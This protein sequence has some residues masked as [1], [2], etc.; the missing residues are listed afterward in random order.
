[1]GRPMTPIP[2]KPSCMVVYPFRSFHFDND[3]SAFDNVSLLVVD[4]PYL[5]RVGGGDGMFHFH[6]AENDEYLA[7]LHCVP[8]AHLDFGDGS[9]HGRGE[10][11]LQA[12]DA[13]PTRS[14]VHVGRLP[15]LQ[16][17]QLPM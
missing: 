15:P 16:A 3:G 9:G 5:A 17:I 11:F 12:G 7:L 4:V 2:I 10:R 1:M 6:S 14:Y 13:A 8:I